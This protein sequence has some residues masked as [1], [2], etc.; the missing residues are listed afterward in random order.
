[1]LAGEDPNPAG[2]GSYPISTLTW[3]LAYQ[4]GNGAKAPAIRQ[5]MLHLLSPQAQGQASGLGYVPLKG[6]ILKQ[7]KAAV[8]KIGS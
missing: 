1:M 5:A 6:Q 2:A 8:A 7:A 3:I 4:K